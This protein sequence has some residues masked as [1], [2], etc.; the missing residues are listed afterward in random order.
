M[1]RVMPYDTQV[2]ITASD[3]SALDSAQ[4]VRCVAQCPDYLDERLM[5]GVTWCVRHAKCQKEKPYLHK[6]NNCRA[7]C[8]AYALDN[9]CVRDCTTYGY[10][11]VSGDV[12]V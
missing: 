7:R 4:L 2:A 10:S 9:V 3:N 6:N 12:C 11:F 1:K 8:P 5:N